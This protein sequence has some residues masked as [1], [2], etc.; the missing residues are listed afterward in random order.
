[1][2]SGVTFEMKVKYFLNFV[3][4]IDKFIQISKSKQKTIQQYWLLTGAQV[5]MSQ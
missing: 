5:L 4:Y 3:R 1:M 2:E